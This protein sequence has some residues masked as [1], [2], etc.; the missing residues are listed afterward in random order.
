M[1]AAVR[2]SGGG[3]LTLWHT[4]WNRYQMAPTWPAELLVSYATACFL[5]KRMNVALVSLA[6]LSLVVGCG[7]SGGSDKPA[8]TAGTANA[9][10]GGGPATAGSAGMTTGGNPAQGG[11]GMGGMPATAGVGGSAGSSNGGSASGA[12]GGGAS[13]AFSCPA[14]VEAAKLT[15]LT[16]TRVAGVPPADDFNN[17]NNDATNIE[18]PV[19]AGG[20]L[21]VSE[22]AFTKQPNPPPSR[23]LKITADGQVSVAIAADSGTNGLAINAQGDLFGAVHKDGSISKLS[24]SGGAATP[25]VSMFMGARFGSPNDLAFHTNGTLYFSDPSWQAPS[26]NPQAATRAYRVPPGGEPVAI[27]V[28][29]QPNGVTLSKKQDFLYIAGNQLK[30]YP[31]MA[32][33]S[34]GAGVPFRMDGAAGQ[35]DGMVIDCA[36][37]LYTTG[38]GVTVYSAAGAELG[39]ISVNGLSSVTNVAFGGADHKTLYIT[40][41]GDKDQKGLWQVPMNIPGMPY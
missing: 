36:D 20:A 4:G 23:V 33:G 22:I 9:G 26:P 13:Q 38:N 27:D 12:G 14:S 11:G 28:L 5:E 21:Y 6:A 40:S 24:V 37:N 18:G 17:N 30:K 3:G 15:G 35:S 10:S 29:D 34:L 16:A 19:W 32:D 41:Q 1:V 25:F 2:H 39:T 8:N 7:G 31:V